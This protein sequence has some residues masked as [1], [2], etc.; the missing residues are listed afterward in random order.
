MPTQAFTDFDAF[1]ATTRHS[2]GTW[3]LTHVV[4]RKWVYT[5]RS[6]TRLSITYGH[7]GSGTL[8]RGTARPDGCVLCVDTT[9]PPARSFNGTHVR[10]QSLV[11]VGPGAEACCATRGRSDWFTVFFPSD[12]L[13]ACGE[14]YRIDA[15]TFTSSLRVLAPPPDRILRL[16]CVVERIE[17]DDR[18]RPWVFDDPDFVAVAESE[19]LSAALE[20]LA[21]TRDS[22]CSFGQPRPA[23][24]CTSH[25]RLVQ[26]ALARL[27]SE[28]ANDQLHV[29]SI[30]E[31]ADASERTLRSAFSDFC[32]V[33]PA[34]Y[35]KLRQLH[36]VRR[37]LMN[38]SRVK[39]TVTEIE[40]HFGISEF[41]RFANEY[42]AVFGECPSETLKNVDQTR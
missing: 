27:D 24:R 1:A 22:G 6:L 37:A 34:R 32:G 28:P 17:S 33:S 35:V 40:S 36:Q 15:D 5:Y 19:L 11:V 3:M 38:A 26:A 29:A 7:E 14:R 12:L 20:C 9:E 13:S 30:A 2:E 23:R 41:G 18:D 42:R 39:R 31:A 10:P 25:A 8:F 4:E 16:R 21:P